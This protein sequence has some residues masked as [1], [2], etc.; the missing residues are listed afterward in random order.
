M[1]RVRLLAAACAAVTTLS[2]LAA[3]PAIAHQGA[4]LTASARGHA[5]ALTPPVDPTQGNITVTVSYGGQALSPN[6]DVRVS[7]WLLDEDLGLYVEQPHGTWTFDG[8]QWASSDL[9]P[10]RYAV[11]FLA[12][13]TDVG[14]EWWDG[15]RYFEESI[16][17]VVTAGATAGLGAVTLDERTLDIGRL[18]GADRFATAVELS[19]VIAPDDSAITVY[20]A[21]GMNYPDALAAGPAAIAQG[22]VLLLTRRDSLP[23]VTRRELERI[24]PA[25]VVIVGGAGAVSAAVEAD[26]TATLP[27]AQV[28]RAAGATRYETGEEVVRDAF[29][30][31]AVTALVATGRNYP[32]ALAAGPAAGVAGAPV[33][34]VDGAASAVSAATMTLLDDLGVEEVFIVGGKG[35]VS[36]GV[37]ASLGTRF[38][39]G[40]HRVD[41]ATRYETA[42]N[43]NWAFFEVAE[44]AFLASGQNFPDAL[45][46][47][48][49]AGAFGAPLFL[50]PSACFGLDAAF[51]VYDARSN[52]VWLLGGSGALSPNV[53]A[54][55]LC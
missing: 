3:T 6:G 14:L 32:D 39:T 48:P 20:L 22:G 46:G 43:L 33:I 45:A 11:R 38:G 26:V 49:L 41:G 12:D 18:S 34:L 42:A 25:R 10:G 4:G 24:R 9:A 15:G 16:D 2:L 1:V 35:A 30:E 31:G 50:S 17:V 55:G 52:G 13:S 54:F 53:E 23:D 37:E 7:F 40:V 19:T 51:G 47:A 5:T 27:G 28:D 44:R 21:D 36:P 29:P 8:A